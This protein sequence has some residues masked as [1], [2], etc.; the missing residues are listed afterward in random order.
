MTRANAWND[1]LCQAEAV[2]EAINAAYKNAVRRIAFRESG[3]LAHD[4]P[5]PPGHHYIRFRISSR[6]H[7]AVS[8]PERNACSRPNGY[9]I[10]EAL[11]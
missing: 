8:R 7:V 4:A 5:A 6:A 3:D 9:N 11:Q 2:D 10:Y 1:D